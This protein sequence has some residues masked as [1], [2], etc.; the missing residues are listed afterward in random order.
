MSGTVLDSGL[1]FFIFRAV[2]G[3]PASASQAKGS[4]IMGKTRSYHDRFY[5]TDEDF[6]TR[7]DLVHKRAYAA[8]LER[9]AK[10]WQR[11]NSNREN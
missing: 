5:Y 11:R 4:I 10:I 2:A 9:E 6:G 7:P 8:Q 1:R 3:N